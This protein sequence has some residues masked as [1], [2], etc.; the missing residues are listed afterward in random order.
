MGMAEMGMEIS[1]DKMYELRLAA[2]AVKLKTKDIH[3]HH[4]ANDAK[5]HLPRP[6]L[7]SRGV[8]CDPEF[9][10]MEDLENKPN[11]FAIEGEDD[12]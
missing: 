6:E 9:R 7:E 12:T 2:E 11:K 8:S 10:E 3:L 1:Y 4:F 5:P